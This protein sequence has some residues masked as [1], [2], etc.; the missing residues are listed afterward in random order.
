MFVSR[1]YPEQNATMPTVIFLIGKIVFRPL[2][3]SSNVLVR[4]VRRHN[5]SFF[6]SNLV[7]RT[8]NQRLSRN[9]PRLYFYTFQ[10]FRSIKN[11][12]IITRFVQYSLIKHSQRICFMKERKKYHSQFLWMG[13]NRTLQ[14]V[15]NYKILQLSTQ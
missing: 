8:V 12:L 6:T 2:R 7:F 4:Y 5:W 13:L 1:Y 10:G 3:F 9:F 14:C 11:N 15:D